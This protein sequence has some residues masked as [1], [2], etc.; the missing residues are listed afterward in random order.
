MFNGWKGNTIFA[1]SEERF[2]KNKNDLGI[3]RKTIAFILE[4]FPNIQIKAICV[5]DLLDMK[6]FSKEYLNFFYFQN[7]ELRNNIFKNKKLKFIKIILKEI[8][9]KKL[10]KQISAKSIW[11]RDK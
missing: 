1:S 3:P 4:S 11:R 5:G 10:F 9:F 2:S 8:L 6:C 7:Y